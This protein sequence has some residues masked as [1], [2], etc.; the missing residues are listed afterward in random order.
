MGSVLGDLL[1]QRKALDVAIAK[2]VAVQ[3]TGK[4]VFVKV[5]PR[6]IEKLVSG[7]EGENVIIAGMGPRHFSK[8]RIKA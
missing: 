6:D 2:E 7:T 5:G 4:I 3:F 1:E 8:V